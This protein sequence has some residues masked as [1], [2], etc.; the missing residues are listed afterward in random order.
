MKRILRCFYLFYFAES[1]RGGS[2]KPALTHRHKK[3]RSEQK[4]AWALRLTVDNWDLM[5]LNSSAQR[6]ISH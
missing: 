6:R 5:K 2:R 3:G 1:E 4:I